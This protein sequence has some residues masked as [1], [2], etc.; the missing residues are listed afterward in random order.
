MANNNIAICQRIFA[1]LSPAEQGRFLANPH[2]FVPLPMPIM[3]LDPTMHP[4][5]TPQPVQ[6]FMFNLED[7]VR[8]NIFRNFSPA[9][10]DSYLSTISPI[11][12]LRIIHYPIDNASLCRVFESMLPA[13]KMV[14]LGT[15]SPDTKAAFFHLVRAIE[16]KTMVFGS[17]GVEQQE[18]ILMIC[19]AKMRMGL[20]GYIYDMP[21]LA[22]AFLS[23]P[24]EVQE[25][26]INTAVDELKG[27][28]LFALEQ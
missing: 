5:P 9:E 8:Q 16:F 23:L 19:D 21:L 6:P 15:C 4:P 14:Y 1:A 13:D 12:K 2:S 10:Q 3:V 22:R 26:V 25:V 17:M 24:G 11:T 7:F 18:I 28:L 20:L 27:R